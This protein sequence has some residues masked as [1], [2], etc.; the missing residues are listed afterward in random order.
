MQPLAIRIFHRLFALL[1]SRLGLKKK[2]DLQLACGHC[3]ASPFDNEILELGRQSLLG[4]L[5][6]AGPTDASLE[7]PAGQPFLLSLVGEYLRLIGDPDHE[8]FF[9][10]KNSLVKRCPC[11]GRPVC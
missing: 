8:L 1:R 6:A 7:I 3:L 2:V 9:R 10:R 11:R 4:E 5:R